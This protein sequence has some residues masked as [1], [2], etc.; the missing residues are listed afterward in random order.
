MGRGIPDFPRSGSGGFQVV[1]AAFI[2]GDLLPFASILS[3]ERIERIFTRHDCQ[4]GLH[5]V[6]T[7]ALM[8]WSFL[9]QVLRD[10]MDASCQAA[11]APGAGA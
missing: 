4:F 7:T 8:V 11:V 9:G 1:V 2:C 5:D 3:A 10:G 6:Y